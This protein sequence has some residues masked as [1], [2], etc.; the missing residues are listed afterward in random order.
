MFEITESDLKEIFALFSSPTNYE[1]KTMIYN[2]NNKLYYKN[3]KL[4]EEYSLTQS[5]KDFAEDSLRAVLY[6]L[7][8]HDY[9]IKKGNV[10]VDIDFITN[11]FF[12]KG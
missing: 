10:V 4:D 7:V 1:L 2:P 11:N 3:E 12:I 6:Y 9:E 8:K 5:K